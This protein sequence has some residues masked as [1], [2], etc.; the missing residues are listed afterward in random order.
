MVL[1]RMPFA[2]PVLPG[3]RLPSR[4]QPRVQRPPPFQYSSALRAGGAHSLHT[5][6][7]PVGRACPV[8]NATG[9]TLLAPHSNQF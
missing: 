3:V 4:L 6:P 1:V 9:G 7:Q 2:T 5:L 8:W